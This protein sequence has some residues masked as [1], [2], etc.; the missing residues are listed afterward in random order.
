M[1]STQ[2]KT[3]AT[4]CSR[5]VC[6]RACVRVCV[7]ACVCVCVCVCVCEWRGGGGGGGE[8]TKRT[9]ILKR[10]AVGNMVLVSLFFSNSTID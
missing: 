1:K 3:Y 4:H 7:R 8:R 9:G 6:V 2:H 10:E 5:T